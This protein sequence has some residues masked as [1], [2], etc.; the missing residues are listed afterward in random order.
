MTPKQNQT[1][2]ARQIH[3]VRLF[4]A[5]RELV[6]RNW[7]EPELIASWFAPDAFLVTECQLDAR[8]GGRWRVQYRSESGSVYTESGEFRELVAPEK[9]VMTLTQEGPSASRGPDTV[10]AV[11][12]EATGKQTRMTFVQT[13]FDSDRHRDENGEGWAECFR[14]LERSMH[15][16]AS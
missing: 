3:V 1:T 2:E 12:L 14:K 10:V 9:I 13:G 6:F 5:P 16:Q 11:T 15:L 4:D 7:T 8:P